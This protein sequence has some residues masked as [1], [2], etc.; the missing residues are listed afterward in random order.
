MTDRAWRTIFEAYDIFS[1]DF[2]SEPFYL[3][4]GD[5]KDVTRQFKATKE[6]EPRILCKH[7]TRESRPQLFQENEL[8]L[9][10]VKN[11]KYA[12]IRGE[13]YV[14][15]PDIQNMPEVHDSTLDFPLETSAAGNS[16]THHIDFAHAT[17]LIRHFVN[18]E[19]LI[20]T[21][22]G[23][24]HTSAFSFKIGNYRIETQGIQTEVNAGY[25]S[26]HQLLLVKSK[27]GFSKNILIRQ[28]YYPYR[29]WLTYSRKQV[30]PILFEKRN[31][32]YMLWRFAFDDVESY[33]SIYLLEAGK[34]KIKEKSAE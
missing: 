7:D 15:I 14:D 6:R 32:E 4:A 25:E 1:H 34:Y 30:T 8:F 11:G 29:H 2:S 28:L 27:K 17:G 21:F 23:R 16:D 12:I 33:N 31:D 3:T 18:A 9:L 24:E 10:P 22:R 26:R 19:T 20:L 5:I 13:G